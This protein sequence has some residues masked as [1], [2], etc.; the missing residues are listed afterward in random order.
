MPARPSPFALDALSDDEYDELAEL[1]ADHSPFDMDGVLGVVH[2][3]AV[4][5]SLVQPSVWLPVVLPS[6]PR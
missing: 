1:L 3:V 6:G 4:A 5:P 2:A